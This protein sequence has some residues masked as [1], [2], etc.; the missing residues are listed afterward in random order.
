MDPIQLAVARGAQ[1]D[2]GGALMT[3]QSDPS[4]I[5]RFCTGRGVPVLDDRGH[6]ARDHHS[7]CPVWQAEKR[8]IWDLRDMLKGGAGPTS[9][10]RYDYD[11]E[12]ATA[13]R[14]ALPP[15]A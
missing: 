9:Q 1:S 4:T 2:L 13:I 8:R 12:P 10:K 3:V 6:Y 14:Q 5:L 7:Y 15:G 11:I